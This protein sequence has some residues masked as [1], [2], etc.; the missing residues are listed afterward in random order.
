M[1]IDASV[2]STD[3]SVTAS[4]VGRVG[5]RSI[6]ENPHR[7]ALR[8]EGEVL[9]LLVDRHE[10]ASVLAELGGDRPNVTRPIEGDGPGFSLARL[11]DRARAELGQL[12]QL[13]PR[14]RALGVVELVAPRLAA[15]ERGEH[16]L[17]RAS[18]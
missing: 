1:T 16:G 9:D 6:R 8:D 17:D 14:A 11:A 15:R 4:W 7:G 5:I 3:S 12:E 18:E 13:L 2:P 10:L